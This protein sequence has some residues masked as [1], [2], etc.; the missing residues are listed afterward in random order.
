MPLVGVIPF[1]D[2]RNDFQGPELGEF[3]ALLARCDHVHRMPHRQRSK[4]AYLEAGLWIVDH[5]DFLVAVWDGKP[6]AGIGGTG[7][8]VADAETKDRPILRIDPGQEQRR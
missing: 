6:A 8:V 5:V 1:E 4:H 2:Y 7:D 3:E